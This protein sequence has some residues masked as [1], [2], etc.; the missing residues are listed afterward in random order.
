MEGAPRNLFDLDSLHF[1]LSLNSRSSNNKIAEL[2]GG[3]EADASSVWRYCCS[4]G[5]LR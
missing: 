5:S 2:F 3:S 1:S 4:L